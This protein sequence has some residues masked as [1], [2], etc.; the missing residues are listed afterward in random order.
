MSV[1]LPCHHSACKAIGKVAGNKNDSFLVSVS[2]FLAP[3][4]EWAVPIPGGREVQE[5]T[6]LL[7]GRENLAGGQN[8]KGTK[9]LAVRGMSCVLQALPA[10]LTLETTYKVLVRYDVCC[11]VGSY[12]EG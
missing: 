2:Q 3:L 11:H 4:V 8:T 5:G 10:L 9:G 6:P 7:G 1:P 12:L